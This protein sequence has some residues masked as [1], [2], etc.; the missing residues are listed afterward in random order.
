VKVAAAVMA[1]FV[2]GN[3]PFTKYWIGTTMILMG[4]FA[5]S[6]IA[7]MADCIICSASVAITCMFLLALIK[8]RFYDKRV[9]QSKE[10]LR[11]LMQMTEVFEDRNE[12]LKYAEPLGRGMGGWLDFA[13]Q[14]SVSGV[15]ALV[16]LFRYFF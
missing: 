10:R 15:I 6:V 13:V 5:L 1:S 3:S 11:D 8:I 14:F 2:P 16:S 12:I 4:M 9:N 7:M